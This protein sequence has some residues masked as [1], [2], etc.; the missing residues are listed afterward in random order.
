MTSEP[1]QWPDDQW[2]S[3]NEVPHEHINHDGRR[4]GTCQFLHGGGAPKL[5]VL[6]FYRRARFIPDS[7]VGSVIHSNF[8]TQLQGSERA[9]L[10]ESVKGFYWSSAYHQWLC[11]PRNDLPPWK[12]LKA[13]HFLKKYLDSVSKEEA[14][15][16]HGSQYDLKSRDG[17]SPNG[18]WCTAML[19]QSQP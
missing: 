18:W 6:F 13:F 7:S 9:L 12:S 8:I 3:E 10:Y 4:R 16:W 2:W 1:L 11:A 15:V 19:P 14:K 17:T 5:K